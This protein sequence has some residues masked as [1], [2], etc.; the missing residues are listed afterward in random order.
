MSG[1]LIQRIRSFSCKRDGTSS[2]RL[3]LNIEIGYKESSPRI[4]L[5]FFGKMEKAERSDV[6][7]L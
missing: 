2:Q 4:R 1:F 7:I 5:A 3:H 6:E